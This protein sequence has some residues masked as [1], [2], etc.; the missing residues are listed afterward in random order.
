MIRIRAI[1]A[2]VFAITLLAGASSQV[3]GQ[4]SVGVGADFVSRYVWRGY[5]AGESFS[6]QPSIAITNGG[7]EIGAW[8]SYSVAADGSGA[9]EA[10]LYASFTLEAESGTSLTV[11][12]TDYYFPAPA[13]KHG[14]FDGEAH[15][16]EPFVSLSGPSTLP[17]SLFAG[18]LADGADRDLY[19]EGSVGWEAAGADMGL[20]LGI[21][22]GES[23]FY[24]VDASAVT[25]ISFTVGKELPITDEFSLPVNAT[26]VVNP[27]MERSFLVFGFSLSN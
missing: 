23:E 13:A 16:W 21:V 12:L 7:F 14:L 24:G 9:N 18:V 4:T 15:L 3:V 22:G 20:A 17:L 5:D 2:A 6:V 10:D 1:P 11:G 25:N 26:Y 27:N 8:G 19:L